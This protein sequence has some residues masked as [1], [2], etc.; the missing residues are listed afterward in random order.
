MGHVLFNEIGAG[1]DRQQ[2]YDVG[3]G[4]IAIGVISNRTW[5]ANTALQHFDIAQAV[6]L[7]RRRI[8]L[9]SIL[10]DQAVIAGTRRPRDDFVDL[11][12]RQSTSIEHQRFLVVGGGAHI[13]FVEDAG[14]WMVRISALAFSAQNFKLGKSFGIRLTTSFRDLAYFARSPICSKLR[15]MFSRYL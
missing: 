4:I 3:H 9:E 13:G 6:E 7:D 14:G 15:L 1:G 11:A 8:G 10:Q 5:P 12:E 2:R